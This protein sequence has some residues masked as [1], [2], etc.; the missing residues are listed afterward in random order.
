M[1]KTNAPKLVTR[2]AFQSLHAAQCQRDSLSTEQLPKR[3]DTPL[4]EPCIFLF[5]DEFKCTFQRQRVSMDADLTSQVCPTLA[6]HT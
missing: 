6:Y 1:S 4:P 3:K 5:S 2:S